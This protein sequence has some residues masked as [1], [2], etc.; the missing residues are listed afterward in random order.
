MTTEF[1][2]V[3]TF[4]GCGGSH[5]GFEKA[6]FKTLFINDINPEMINT[7]KLN[8]DLNDDEY[9]VGKIQDVSK[10]MILT[11]KKIKNVITDV[12]CGGVVCKGFSLAGIRN[13]SDLRNYLYLDQL[14]LVSELR[15][16]ISVIEN[17][18]QFKTTNILKETTEN[19]EAINKLRKLYDKKKQNNGKKTNQKNNVKN[20]DEEHQNICKEINNLENQLKNSLYSVFEHI[21]QLY[22]EKGY[23]V[24]HKILT[25]ADYGDY[26][27]R[28]RFFIIAIRNDVHE[29]CGEFSFPPPTHHKDASSGLPIW[30][31]VGECFQE[32]D[33]NGSNHPNIDIDNKPMKHNEKTIKRF[34][35]IPKGGSLIDVK[36]K[37]P[38]ELQTKKV[39]S[40]RGSSKRLDD[41]KCSP[42]LVPGHSAFPVHPIENRSITIREGAC[43][44]GFPKNYKFSGSHTKRCEQIGNAIPVNI[45]YHL[46]LKIKDY[47]KHIKNFTI[48]EDYKNE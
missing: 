31:T 44:T 2:I 47:L 37:L 9:Y 42:T 30:K 11:K 6:G 38:K 27:S 19:E 22:H 7:I 36:D 34:S 3:E 23:I 13:P 29:Q 26:T 45:A 46:A 10:Q 21:K 18:P 4:V 14:R 24:Y 20:L 40:S 15:P 16:R 1:N 17:V 35:Y 8:K 43:L 39:F 12:L 25:C 28:K 5:L 32:I 33:Y 41:K 48:L